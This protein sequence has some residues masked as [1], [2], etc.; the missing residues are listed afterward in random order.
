VTGRMGEDGEVVRIERGI[1]ANSPETRNKCRTQ[2]AVEHGMVV[3]T[4]RQDEIQ[5]F[6]FAD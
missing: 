1:F 4:I 3:K 2:V 5:G 6:G